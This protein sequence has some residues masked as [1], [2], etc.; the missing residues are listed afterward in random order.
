MVGLLTTNK[1]LIRHIIQSHPQRLITPLLNGWGE[2]LLPTRYSHQTYSSVRFVWFLRHSQL[3]DRG[4]F[5]LMIRITHNYLQTFSD[6]PAYSYGQATHCLSYNNLIYYA[7][8]TS[9]EFEIFLFYL[10][11]LSLRLNHSRHNLSS[12]IKRK[13]LLSLP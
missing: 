13:I 4:Y 3:A 9:M 1:P 5:N 6:Y 7:V 12:Y 2:W 8:H 10:S 11:R